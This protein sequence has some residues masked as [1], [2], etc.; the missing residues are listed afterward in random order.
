MSRCKLSEHN[1]ENFIIRGRFS[2]KNAKISQKF[3]PI[4]ATSG[5]R[6]S[7]H[8]AILALRAAHW[9][10]FLD[11][12]ALVRGDAG[13]ENGTSCG[14]TSRRLQHRWQFWSWTVWFI[15][16]SL[17]KA[18]WCLWRVLTVF[19]H[20][21]I[22]PPVVKR[23]GWKL[24]HSEYIVCRWP[25]QG[26]HCRHLSNYTEPSIYSGDVPYVCQITFTTCYLLT[27]T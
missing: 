15:L 21:A 19:T 9:D 10:E 27:P 24:G 25:W 2:P 17:A 14:A 4:L 6:N 3:F 1:C 8:L 11:I 7:A 5:H 23:F 13:R 12:A 18:A 16:K 22:T 26:T 20:S